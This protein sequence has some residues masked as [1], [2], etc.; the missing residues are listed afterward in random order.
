[1]QMP[2]ACTSSSVTSTAGANWTKLN[3][4]H[5]PNGMCTCRIRVSG[6]GVLYIADVGSTTADVTYT[7]TLGTDAYVEIATGSVFEFMANPQ[8]LRFKTSSTCAVNMIVS[9]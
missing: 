4:A 9:W 2:T 6:L 3:A 8:F 5:V 1:M 7:P